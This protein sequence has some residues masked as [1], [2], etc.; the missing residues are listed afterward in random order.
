MTRASSSR[1]RN[2]KRTE[3]KFCDLSRNATYIAAELR[4]M[5][6][7]RPLL[8]FRPKEGKRETASPKSEVG[9]PSLHLL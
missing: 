2:K 1:N 8:P 5:L 4:D 7:A 6:I 9:I 3:E